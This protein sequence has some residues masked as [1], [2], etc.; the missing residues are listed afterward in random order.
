MGKKLSSKKK[1]QAKKRSMLVHKVNGDNCLQGLNFNG[2]VPHYKQ[3]VRAY[4]DQGAKTPAWE[5]ELAK[6]YSN[7]S[8]C[9]AK[10]GQSNDAVDYSK[11]ALEQLRERCDETRYK[12]IK[13]T[14]L[15]RLHIAAMHVGDMELCQ[16]SMA[17]S[18]K[19][20]TWQY[21]DQGYCNTPE[22]IRVGRLQQAMFEVL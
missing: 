8:V 17:E 7:L 13:I 18:N 21:G 22:H 19:L 9:L 11:L 3:A 2:A 6:V 4:E 16:W 1:R 14:T 5:I 20:T 10:Q 15:T 12:K